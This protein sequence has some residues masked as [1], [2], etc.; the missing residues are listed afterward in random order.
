[1]F[2]E[3][4]RKSHTF[5]YGHRP[6]PVSL[7]SCVEV[8]EA[9]WISLVLSLV[10]DLPM[11]P[12]THAFAQSASGACRALRVALRVAATVAGLVHGKEK[13]WAG[14]EQE[15]SRNVRIITRDC[16]GGDLN[17]KLAFNFRTR[18]RSAH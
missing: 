14:L 5:H 7:P 10:Q 3:V 1:M 6:S 12:R 2:I 15:V 13:Y 17:F 8:L 9:P 18:Q 11:A 4:N 16:K